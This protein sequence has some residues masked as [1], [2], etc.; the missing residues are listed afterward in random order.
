MKK[1]VGWIIAAVLLVAIVCGAFWGI[2][3]N[4]N[5]D[6]EKNVNITKIDE[7]VNKD[8]QRQYPK[9]PREVVK[10]YNKILE[11]F[12]NEN[13]TD[14][15]VKKLCKKSL[16]LFDDDLKKE[17]P[18]DSYLSSV[19]SDIKKYKDESKTIK[20]STVCSSN[21]VMYKEDKGAEIAYVDA[22]Y[23]MKDKKG[24]AKTFQTYVL[25]KDK[26]SQWKILV[27]YKIDKSSSIQE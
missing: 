1:T 17:N 21:D 2:S 19:K 25:R 6:V 15:Q 26:N 23:F 5:D 20:Q 12:Y 27:W 10:H 16:E 7:V 22:S 13:P 11:C 18:I 8:L 14:K 24:F 3:K 9:T 4:K